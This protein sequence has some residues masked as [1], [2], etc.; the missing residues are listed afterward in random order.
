ME[1]KFKYDKMEEELDIIK[2]KIRSL[3]VTIEPVNYWENTLIG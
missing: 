1:L 2:E 3:P